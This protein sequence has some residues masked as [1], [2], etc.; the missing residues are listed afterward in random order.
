MTLSPRMTRYLVLAP[1]M[2]LSL[3]LGNLGYA[4]LTRLGAC[5]SLAAV[6]IT[7]LTLYRH[8]QSRWSAIDAP[9]NPR[10]EHARA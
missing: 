4:P 7:G 8:R 9:T 6:L 3:A 10:G 5:L 2:I 1:T